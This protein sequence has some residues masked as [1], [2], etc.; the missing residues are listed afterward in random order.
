MIMVNKTVLNQAQLPM[1]FLWGQLV[2]AV[3]LLHGAER[4]KM[5][6]LPPLSGE[7]VKNLRWLVGMNVVGLALNTLCL[8]H[9]DAALYQVARSLILPMTA[10]LSVYT[11][12]GQH[13]HVSKRVA[14][15][16]IIITVGFLIGIVGE[17]QVK[18]STVG[19][20][21]GVL[22]SAATA[23][24]S[25]AIKHSF[26]QVPHNGAFDMVYYNNL[27]SAVLLL[28]IVILEG[29]LLVDYYNSHDISAIWRFFLGTLLAGAS[30]LLI[31]LAGF[32]QIKVTSPLTHT[33]SSAARGV[34]QTIACRVFLGEAVTIARV[35]GILTTLFGSALYS[36]FKSTEQH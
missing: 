14:M 22:S 23:I 16:C 12:L 11:P 24:H 6:Q 34:L 26:S 28:P 31:N 10:L 17:R 35:A 21:F 3:V 20:V 13:G 8:Q 4:L 9:I 27:F 1:T 30:G 18:V 19:V 2:M 25:F 7:V 33:V 15:S 5:L 29:P 32:L 36:V